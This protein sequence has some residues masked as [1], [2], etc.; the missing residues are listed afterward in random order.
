MAYVGLAARIKNGKPHLRGVVLDD[1][2][3]GDV[4]TFDYTPPSGTEPADMIHSVCDGLAG[5][6]A[7]VKTGVTRVVIR[8]ADDGGRGGMTKARVLRARAEGGVAYVAREECSDVRILSGP[9][10]GRACGDNLA[11][12]EEQAKQIA[13]AVWKEAASAALAAKGLDRP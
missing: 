5:Q 11:D 2:D 13:A 10:V 3:P 6:F 7:N 8:Q 9:N 4:R 1:P 12:A